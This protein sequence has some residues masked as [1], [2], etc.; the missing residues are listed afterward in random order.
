M[1]LLLAIA[2][3]F[4]AQLKG[5]ATSLCG[6][7]DLGRYEAREVD[8]FAPGMQDIA[9][10]RTMTD[11]TLLVAGRT[12]VSPVADEFHLLRWSPERGPEPLA[13][14]FVLAFGLRE[15]LRADRDGGWWY[16]A[17]GTRENVVGATFVQ[18]EE[19]QFV[20][21]PFEGPE[22]WL[23]L[24]VPQPRGLYVHDTAEGTRFDDV[25]HDGVVRSWIVSG[26]REVLPERWTAEALPDGRVAVIAL[27]PRTAED[28]LR[29]R[30]VLTILGNDPLSEV[31]LDERDD[32]VRVTSAMGTG[33]RMALVLQTNTALLGAIV[34]PLQPTA[35]EW[36]PLSGDSAIPKVIASGDDFVVA[37]TSNNVLRAR[38]LKREATVDVATIV[39]RDDRRRFFSVEAD[40]DELLFYWQGDHLGT[41]RL[42]ANLAGFALLDILR[43]RCPPAPS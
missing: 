19:Q 41:R 42:P 25:R 29:A 13:R 21:V 39:S 12:P 30:V 36:Q 23:P 32:L 15:W 33:G 17:V 3:L 22:V 16:S 7:T 27:Q 2:A 34:D 18:E 8:L 14:P 11:G 6:L 1:K 37:W 20:R 38:T 4:V 24:D 31:V 43:L 9:A 26:R 5:C 10:V 40:G 35:V 28:I